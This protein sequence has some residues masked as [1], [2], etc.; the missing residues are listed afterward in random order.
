MGD[1]PD[2]LLPRVRGQ[3]GARIEAVTHDHTNRA[4]NWAVGRVLIP[5][6]CF[7]EALLKHHFLDKQVAEGATQQIILG[8]EL[9]QAR[10][11]QV[12]RKVAQPNQLRRCTGS[13]EPPHRARGFRCPPTIIGHLAHAESV[14]NF[15]RG[16]LFL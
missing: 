8:L 1:A 4:S 11:W 15:G 9:A 10:V 16:L 7:P 5:S 2:A 14:R 12:R 6:R 3:L 13:I